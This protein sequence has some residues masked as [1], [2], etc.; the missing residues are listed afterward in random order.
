MGPGKTRHTQKEELNHK[1]LN[2]QITA[3]AD[4]GNMEHLLWVIG[5][6]LEW[7]NL[8]NFSTAVHRTAKLALSCGSQSRDYYMT[9]PLMHKLKD[10]LVDYI[11]SVIDENG[12]WVGH[13][14]HGDVASEMRCLSIICWSCATLRLRE[15][16]LF[17]RVAAAS[18]G[19]L[20]EMKPF[21]LS[22]L[23]WSFAKL[24]LGDQA[25][26]NSVAPHLLRRREGEF[27]S[28]CLATIAWA[29]GTVKAHHHAVFSSFA[30]ELAVVAPSM[31]TQGIA[32]TVWAFARVR[33]QETQLFR[34]LADAACRDHMVT[35][36]KTQEL[37][38]TAW[39]FATVGLEHPQLFSK[40]AEVLVCRAWE[41]PP[42][43]MAN[44]LWAYAKL[45]APCRGRVFPALL[46][47]T[48]SRLEQYKPQEVSA[49]L[50]AV[51]REIAGGG[52]GAAGGLYGALFHSVPMHFE[53]RLGDFTSQALACM[54][55]AFTLAE[56]DGLPFFDSVIR[57][58]LGRLPTFEPPSLCTLLRGLV[59]H[60]RKLPPDAASNALPDLE[61]LAAHAL[62]RLRE[63]LPHNALHLMQSLESVPQHLTGSKTMHDLWKALQVT[64]MPRSSSAMPMHVQLGSGQ[65]GAL[66]LAGAAAEELLD[67][68]YGGG[69]LEPAWAADSYDDVV[70]PQGA[71]VPMTQLATSQGQQRAPRA[72]QA[73]SAAPLTVQQ[74]QRPPY[75][76]PPQYVLGEMHPKEAPDTD[77][78]HGLGNLGGDAPQNPET[79]PWQ[80]MLPPGLEGFCSPLTPRNAFRSEPPALAC[81]PRG[82]PDAWS[83]H[84]PERKFDSAPPVTGKDVSLPPYVQL[85]LFDKF[86][87][88]SLAMSASSSSQAHHFDDTVARGT[89][90]C[91]SSEA[92]TSASHAAPFALQAH[93]GAPIEL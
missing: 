90:W 31:A 21:E 14:K 58:G 89:P 5:S 6:N 93:L 28:Q 78:D 52:D 35:T 27:S 22:N 80:P 91:G 3:A 13:R 36:F 23:L 53:H 83:A 55:E 37:S 15:H 12:Q 10:A 85:S 40:I 81:D 43:N 38:N 47:V 61:A 63:M 64:P 86:S 19:R 48:L 16:V 72:Q 84:H 25:F 87:L 66:N 1:K 51:A 50:W 17:Q 7:M 44:M 29:F 79:S 54:A 46:E 76:P 73:Y 2:R 20:G 26:F 18:H 45:S 92:S 11:T 65:P 34:A 56:A 70:G 8:I 32:N 74:R 57:E 30:R 42:Q 68:M 49:I 24:S 4:T 62:N 82:V 39:A 71:S 41:L 9:N 59:L 69:S 88:H 77:F 33:R 67:P 75:M 60:L